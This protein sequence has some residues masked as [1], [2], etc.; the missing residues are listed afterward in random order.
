MEDGAIRLQGRLDDQ[1]SAAPA[2]ELGALDAALR[3]RRLSP[4]VASCSWT[5][6]CRCCVCPSPIDAADA[7]RSASGPAAA[8]ACLKP[9]VQPAAVLFAKELPR[10][11]TDKIDRRAV[12]S[13][14][15]AY[16][17][18]PTV[19]NLHDNQRRPR[20]LRGGPRPARRRGYFLRGARRHEPAGRRGGVRLGVAPTMC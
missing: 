9:Y 10:T 8:R 15:S 17:R 3:P 19:A 1:I 20:R 5:T 13:A 16:D 2:D 12:A 6:R 18:S 4:R 7:S 11:R 14:V